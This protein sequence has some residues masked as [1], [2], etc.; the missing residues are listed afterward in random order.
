MANMFRTIEEQGGGSGP[1]WLSDHPNPG[2]R[3]EYIEA[4]ARQLHV[5]HPVR[6]TGELAELQSRFR[7]MAP[8]PTAAEVARNRPS[9]S[10]TNGRVGGS[11]ERPSGSYRTYSEGNLFR[12]SVPSN[13][14]PAESRNLVRF[15]PDGAYGEVNGQAVFTHGFEI[16]V[17]RAPTNSLSNATDQLLNQMAQG[18]PQLRQEGGYRKTQLSGRDALDVRLSNVSE[19][20]G[21]PETVTLQTTLLADGNLLYALGVAPREDFSSYSGVFGNIRRSI[22]ITD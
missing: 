21:K 13:W 1:Q 14:R 18:N 22:Q 12:V 11:V 19:V 9:G 17:L 8:A 7:G 10:G 15:A 16:G 3:R 6:D 2:N 5:D 4:E 20:N